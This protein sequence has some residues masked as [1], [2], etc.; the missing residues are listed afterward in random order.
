MKFLILNFKLL[1]FYLLLITNVYAKESIAYV[2][3]SVIINSSKA[4]L[5]INNQMKKLVDQNNKEYEKLEKNLIKEEN[6]LLKK[7]KVSDP[8]KFNDEIKAFQNKIKEFKIKRKKSVDIIQNKNIIAKSELVNHVTKILAEYS[9]KNEISLI[10]NKESIVI[11]KKDI[12]ITEKVLEL[13][14]GKIKNI[15][16][17]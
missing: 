12:E 16:L 4:G 5:S 6:D 1:F 13:L 15:K 8:K 10:L 2:D 11:G 14:N 7:K 9:T 17:K 3:M